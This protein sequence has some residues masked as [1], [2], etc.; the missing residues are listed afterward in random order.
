MQDTHLRIETVSDELHFV[1]MHKGAVV[2]SVVPLS[3][4]TGGNIMFRRSELIEELSSELKRLRCMLKLHQIDDELH[5]ANRTTREYT[6][7]T[8]LH[9][10]QTLLWSHDA[11]IALAREH[12]RLV[13][14]IVAIDIIDDVLAWMLEG[15]YF[16]E[17]QSNDGAVGFGPSLKMDEMMIATI[18]L[19]V[20]TFVITPCRMSSDTP[21]LPCTIDLPSVY[22]CWWLLCLR[23]LIWMRAGHAYEH[24]S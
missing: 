15:W 1:K 3:A 11:K 19:Q 21:P 24:S 17:R 13:A 2:E 16:G 6:E 18:D 7:C 12:N 22:I 10:Y 20:I 5:H 9:G 14:R 4:R 23:H 8:A